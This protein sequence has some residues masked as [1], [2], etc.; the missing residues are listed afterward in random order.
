MA[1]RKM[2]E[3]A[4]VSDA[5]HI[6]GELA[7]GSQVKIKKSDLA[8]LISNILGLNGWKSYGNIGDKSM[9]SI[10]NGFG[11]SGGGSSNSGIDGIFLSFN[12]S[13]AGLQLKSDINSDTIKFRTANFNRTWRDWKTISF[14]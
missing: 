1:D 6:Y 14:T 10:D 3:F 11:Y 2:N 7:D 5:A 9:D 4:L 13:G 8:L 12:Y